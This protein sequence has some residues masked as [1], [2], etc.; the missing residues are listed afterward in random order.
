MVLFVYDEMDAAP[1]VVIIVHGHDGI[2]WL[3]IRTP[4][5]K[6]AIFRNSSGA[7]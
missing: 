5:R 2:T 1:P 7:R 4:I 3:Q 6:Y